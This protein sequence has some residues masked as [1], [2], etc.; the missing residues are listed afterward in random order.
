MCSTNFCCKQPILEHISPA[1]GDNP[2]D[3]NA[4]S[5]NCRIWR[6]I[7]SFSSKILSSS[8]Q[9]LSRNAS[10][11]LRSA[12][13]I[14]GAKAKISRLCQIHLELAEP[15]SIRP[16]LEQDVKLHIRQAL[17]LRQSEV[18]PNPAQAACARPE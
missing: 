16:L 17:R 15:P 12:C 10:P 8:T 9:P 11:P 7:G 1:L 6:T 14:R 13:L 5:G 2:A 18:A 4:Q 3:R